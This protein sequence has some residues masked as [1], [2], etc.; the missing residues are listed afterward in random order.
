MT[1]VHTPEQRSRNMS[2]I[3]N[4]NTAPEM[5]V[6]RA[7]HALGFRYRLHRKDL[8]GRPDI[9]IPKYNAVIFVHGCFWHLHTCPY[10][11]PKP[12]TNADFWAQKRKGNLDRDR[13]NHRILKSLGWRVFVVW[14]CETRDPEKLSSAVRRLV[15]ILV[16]ETP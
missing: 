11:K 14:E 9:V 12:A 6:R 8:P 7:L 2:A 13:R 15:N 4:K 10:G 3:R 5:S 16:P 1:D